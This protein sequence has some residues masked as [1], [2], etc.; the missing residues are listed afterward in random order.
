MPQV[1][2]WYFIRGARLYKKLK[3]K[4]NSIYITKKF[5]SYDDLAPIQMNIDP[6]LRPIV[7]LFGCHVT[8]CVESKTELKTF[9]L[10]QK[11]QEDKH[12]LSKKK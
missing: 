5:K 9:E 6:L 2:M 3:K 12:K 8:I 1:D 11:I 7:L 10:L 4:K